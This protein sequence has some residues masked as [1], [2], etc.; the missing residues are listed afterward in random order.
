MRWKSASTNWKR[1]SSRL[2]SWAPRGVPTK[3]CTSSITTA[4]RPANS[5]RSS[6]LGE[7][8]SS[9]RLS[10]VVR[11]ASCGSSLKAF[12]ASVPT[13]PC[14]ANA[15][16]RRRPRFCRLAPGRSRHRPPP[17]DHRKGALAADGDGLDPVQGAPALP[18]HVE[19]RIDVQVPRRPRSGA[20][21]EEEL[22]LREL[23]VRLRA[24]PLEPAARPETELPWTEDVPPAAGLVAYQ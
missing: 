20:Q 8:S 4:R 12:R 5:D 22:A 21:V 1:R 2:A 16:A 3:A 11:R 10:G 18:H 23:P 7:V 9:S 6:W 17:R 13:S 15:E 14:Q 24:Q 19:E